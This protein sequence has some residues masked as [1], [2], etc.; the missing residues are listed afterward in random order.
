MNAAFNPAM[1]NR[2]KT[3][4]VNRRTTALMMENLI[5]KPK[6]MRAPPF[7]RKD[8]PE[9]PA[10]NRAGVVYGFTGV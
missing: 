7:G 1:L 6:R 2:M 4:M 9:A 10:K 3:H 8:C 5:I